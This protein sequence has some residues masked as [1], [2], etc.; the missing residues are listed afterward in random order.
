[1]SEY[2]QNMLWFSFH[3]LNQGVESVSLLFEKVMVF[4]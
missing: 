2:L 3:C 4:Y 1:M